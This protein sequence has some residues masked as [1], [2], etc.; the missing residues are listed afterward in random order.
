MAI[1]SAPDTFTYFAY[2]SNMSTARL[3]AR[4]P[5]C[6][7]LGRARLALHDLLFHKYSTKD[8]TGKCD[9]LYTE[10]T[11]DAVIGVLFE[12]ARSEKAALDRAEGL[13]S[14]YNE[15]KIVVIDENDQEVEA[16]TYYADSDAIK[17]SLLPTKEYKQ[18][19]LDGA[20]EHGIPTDYVAA[21]IR[22][23]ATCD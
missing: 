1:P 4:T 18:Y 17:S 22:N 21:K 9:A 10:S 13:G 12:I 14:G 5:S 23:I 3:R 7:S 15:K 2:G 16:L 8:H 6:R 20:E 19:V 11:T